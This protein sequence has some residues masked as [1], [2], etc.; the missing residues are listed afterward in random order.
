MKMKS[1]L[2][3]TI[4]LF[5]LVDIVISYQCLDLHGKPVDWFI[6]YKLP[7]LRHNIDPMLKNG[8]GH[9]YM[10]PNVPNFQL[11]KYSLNSTTH[12]IYHTLQQFYTSKNRSKSD[13]FALYNDWSPQKHENTKHGHTKG[14]VLFDQ[15]KGFWLVHSVPRFPG[16]KDEGYYWPHSALDFGQSLLCMTYNSNVI[17]EIGKQFLFNYPRFYERWMPPGMQLKYPNMWKA[18]NFGVSSTTNHTV[19]FKSSMG[20]TFTVFAKSGTFGQDLY[21]SLVA[22]HYKADMWTETWQNGQDKLPSNCTSSFKVLNVK[23][24]KFQE[25]VQFEEEKDHSKWGVTSNGYVCIGDINRMG[26][27]FRRGGGTVCFNNTAVWKNFMSLITKLDECQL[28]KPAF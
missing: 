10:D 17:D 27:Q 3:L 6:V 26:T 19:S 15:K 23:W 24:I 8:D 16:Y 22:P 13:F 7:F 5:K 14:M 18:L 25:N 12:A 21:S 28:I 4:Y 2:F 11:S 9:Y 20:T 1:L